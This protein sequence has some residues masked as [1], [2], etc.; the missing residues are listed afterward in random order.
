[1]NE[2]SKFIATEMPHCDVHNDA[3]T[4]KM[5]LDQGHVGN[6]SKFMTLLNHYSLCNRSLPTYLLDSLLDDCPDPA[7]IT[8]E[9]LLPWGNNKLEISNRRHRIAAVFFLLNIIMHLESFPTN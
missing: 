4:K 5:K 8:M 1:M 7:F 9:G 6:Q 2:V 3:N